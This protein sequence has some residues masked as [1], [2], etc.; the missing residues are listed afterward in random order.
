MSKSFKSKK[1]QV[2]KISAK[3]FWSKNIFDPK[4][5]LIQKVFGEKN[6]AKKSYE[7]KIL[8]QKLLGTKNV[9]V[10]KKNK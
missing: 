3:H 1:N 7:K 8:F 2:Q 5:F 6:L 10:K 4:R 9:L